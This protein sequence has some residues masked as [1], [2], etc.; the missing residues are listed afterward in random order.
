VAY[1]DIALLAADQDYA[2]RAMAAYA[3]E[4]L[5]DPAAE[6]PPQW[7][8]AHAWDMAAMPGFG[9]AYASAIASGVPRPGKDPGV[10]TDPQLLSAVQAV[11]NE[12]AAP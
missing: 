1:Y 11:L 10:I 7:W 5:S 8:S 3:V 12:G 2:Q 6:D 9:E 4:T